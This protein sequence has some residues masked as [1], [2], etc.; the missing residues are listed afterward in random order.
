MSTSSREAAKK[1]SLF[2][3]R[4]N[5][6]LK[7]VEDE[8]NCLPYDF[9]ALSPMEKEMFL[10]S[11]ADTR[12]K[13]FEF[14]NNLRKKYLAVDGVEENSTVEIYSL[15]SPLLLVPCVDKVNDCLARERRITIDDPV[16]VLMQVWEQ[17]VYTFNDGLSSKIFAKFDTAEGAERILRM[18]KL[19]YTDVRG[20]TYYLHFGPALEEKKRSD[21]MAIHSLL[22][23]LQTVH[24]QLHSFGAMETN[25]PYPFKVEIRQ[26]L[27]EE[28]SAYVTKLETLKRKF[29][30][31]DKSDLVLLQKKP[32]KDLSIVR[33]TVYRLSDE[34]IK[35]IMSLRE[36]QAQGYD[37]DIDLSF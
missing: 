25:D 33:A 6:N 29:E 19:E 12:S 22:G 17:D 37:F 34:R 35:I 23:D 11:I 36:F 18:N 13:L 3:E 16:P 20:H 27:V 7:T 21:W 2:K 28:A 30:A 26:A 5:Y 31:G 9:K 1:L 24:S 14:E 8:C 15:D 32:I 10:S 4:M